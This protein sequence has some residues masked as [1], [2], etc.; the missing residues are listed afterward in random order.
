M[1]ALAIC[2]LKRDGSNNYNL[3]LCIKPKIILC[4]YQAFLKLA[5]NKVEQLPLPLSTFGN[6]LSSEIAM[7]LRESG[8]PTKGDKVIRA[9]QI[10]QQIVSGTWG[11]FNPCEMQSQSL[12][13]LKANRR[14]ESAKCGR[15]DPTEGRSPEA[16]WEFSRKSDSVS[17]EFERD[18]DRLEG[19]VVKNQT[20]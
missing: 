15:E 11:Q 17:I 1:A 16:G 10:C 19:V 8:I 14:V 3:L 5:W 20:G 9:S 18:Q 13:R 4:F 7:F 2:R 12:Q 6:A